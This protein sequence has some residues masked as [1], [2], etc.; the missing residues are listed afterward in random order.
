MFID[1]EEVN[2]FDSKWESKFKNLVINMLI[3]LKN[4][5]KE[6]YETGEEGSKTF[7]EFNILTLIEELIGNKYLSLIQ[8]YDED[9]I[10]KFVKN[11]F[12]IIKAEEIKQKCTEGKNDNENSEKPNLLSVDEIFKI[13]NKDKERLEKEKKEKT[14]DNSQKK[15]SDFYYLTSLFKN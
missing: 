14:E 7:I 3:S 13:A 4:E 9:I 2:Q 8:N 5:I 10:H 12:T 11:L 1:D 15:Y 6:V